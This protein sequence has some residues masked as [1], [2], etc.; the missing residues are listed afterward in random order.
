MGALI[1]SYRCNG[2]AVQ[3][4]Q[5]TVCRNSLHLQRADKPSPHAKSWTVDNT[6]NNML[7]SAAQDGPQSTISLGA[8]V[9]ACGSQV[10]CI[11]GRGLYTRTD[12]GGGLYPTSISPQ[13][14][15]TLEVASISTLHAYV[16]YQCANVVW[17][18][19]GLE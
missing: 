1:P 13:E 4:R 6:S 10:A 16:Y 9:Y 12:H 7:Q 14:I 18:D 8:E 3:Q 2:S 11:A 17:P 5:R 15:R 19:L